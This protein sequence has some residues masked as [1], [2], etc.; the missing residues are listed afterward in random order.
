M[1]HLIRL[2]CL[3]VWIIGI[4]LAKGFWS[5]LLALVFPFWAFYLCIEFFFHRLFL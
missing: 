5:T 1:I 4:T 2:V 3:I